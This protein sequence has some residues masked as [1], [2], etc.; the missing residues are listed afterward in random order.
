M[1]FTIA[2]IALFGLAAF[3][4]AAPPHHTPGDDNN[5]VHLGNADNG[6]P[7]SAIV[8]QKVMVF[9]KDTYEDGLKFTASKPV[10][11]DA[12][13]LAPKQHPDEPTKPPGGDAG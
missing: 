2:T 9:L 3:A 13:V 11:S 7:A 6:K 4:A 8:G 10:S 5:T 1:R 12:K